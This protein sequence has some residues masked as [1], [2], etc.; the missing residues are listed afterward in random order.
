ME[1][2]YEESIIR[3]LRRI[4]RAIG[5]HSRYLASKFG[6]TIPQL[7][8]L[9][10]LA[11]IGEMTPG[12]LAKE[13]SLSQGT[14][15]GIIDRLT[16]RQLVERERST[17]DRRQVLLAITPTG[18]EMI[19]NAPSPLQEQFAQQ[20]VALPEEN[21][22]IIHT[23]LKQIIRMMK[24]E[25]VEAAPLLSAESL[26]VLVSEGEE[27]LNAELGEVLE[28]ETDSPDSVVSESNEK[29]TDTKEKT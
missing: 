4:N 8:C 5:I 17:K 3:S 28:G 18:R 20:L 16:A 10:T 7:I 6:L 24:A 9:R 21:Q 27:S 29:P 25:K 13:V 15:T 12:N 22:H 14:I 2:K 19:E 1:S 23:V 26:T 11:R